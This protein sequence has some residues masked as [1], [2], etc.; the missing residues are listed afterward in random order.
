[1]KWTEFKIAKIF[2][3]IWSRYTARTENTIKNRQDFK[4]YVNP[5]I[6]NRVTFF[7]FF[8]IQRPK[9]TSLR[10][11]SLHQTPLT[12]EIKEIG[13][14]DSWEIWAFPCAL[15]MK[16]TYRASVGRD[17]WKTNV[18]YVGTWDLFSGY[19]G[20]VKKG[21]RG[22]CFN[23]TW[24]LMEED[25]GN[26]IRELGGLIKGQVGTVTQAALVFKESSGLFLRGFGGWCK[27]TSGL[28]MEFEDHIKRAV[29]GV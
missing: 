27:E 28:T 19:V 18:C 22:I 26:H 11:E 16:Q 17:A 1:M 5:C 14:Y 21:G 12:R 4:I 20:T 6:K 7:F 29:R 8:W 3:D 24:A 10:A 25:V 15:R 2:D 23:K 13:K 9:P